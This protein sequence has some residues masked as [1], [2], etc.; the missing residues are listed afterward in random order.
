MRKLEY[1]RQAARRIE[2]EEDIYY[3]FLPKA[4]YRKGAHDARCAPLYED[5]KLA[6]IYVENF[7]KVCEGDRVVMESELHPYRVPFPRIRQEVG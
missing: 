4:F 5:G 7:F 6:G 2:A 3:M 1:L